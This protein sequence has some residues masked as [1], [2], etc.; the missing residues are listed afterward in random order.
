MAGIETNPGPRRQFFRLG[1]FNASGAIKK[2]TGIHDIIHDNK[3]DAL[4]LC[5]TISETDAM[6]PSRGTSTNKLQNLASTPDYSTRRTQKGRWSCVYHAE[7]GGYNFTSNAVY[8]LSCYVRDIIYKCSCWQPC[9][10]YCEQ[11]QT[12]YGIGKA[13]HWWVFETS[14]C[15][16]SIWRPTHTVRGC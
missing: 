13:V 3:L 2:A 4:A 9:V 5:E 6:M 12:T 1:V 16:H 8:Q 10:S 7:G 11:L 14:C 15:T